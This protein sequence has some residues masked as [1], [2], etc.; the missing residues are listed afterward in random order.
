MANCWPD[1]QRTNGS[2]SCAAR[3]RSRSGDRPDS[4]TGAEK[5]RSSDGTGGLA[6]STKS[7]LVLRLRRQQHAGAGDC[8]RGSPS[9]RV[10]SSW[11]LPS[12]RPIATGM[13]SGCLSGWPGVGLVSWRM[14]SV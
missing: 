7:K 8:A 13:T 10:A 3:K 12:S 1:S 11:P 5:S 9:S 14:V 2:V 6:T 4:F